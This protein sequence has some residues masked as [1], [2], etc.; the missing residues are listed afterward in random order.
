MNNR[1]HLGLI[2]SFKNLDKVVTSYKFTLNEFSKSFKNLYI[3][4]S[5]YLKFFPDNFQNY[6][7]LDFGSDLS[8]KIKFINLEN[9][10]AFKQFIHNKKIILI[11]TLGNSFPEMKI[12]YFLNQENVELIMISN[13]G[14]IQGSAKPVLSKFISYYFF[15]KIPYLIS[16]MLYGIGVFKKIK[17]RF[18]T[19]KDIYDNFKKKTFSYV[20]KILL[21]N[22]RSFDESKLNDKKIENNSIVFLNPDINHPEWIIKRGFVGQNDEIKIYKI[23]EIFLDSLYLFYKKKIIVCIHPYNNLRKITNLFKKYEVVQFKTVENVRNAHL[24][25]FADSSSITD[26]ITLK[27]RIVCIKKIEMQPKAL[28]FIPSYHNQGLFEVILKENFKLNVDGLEKNILNSIKNYD[29]LNKRFGIPD[30]ENIGVHKVI[31]YIN[32]NY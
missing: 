1:I 13:V 19:N 4:N 25:V 16:L 31:N 21:I 3:V 18:L 32:N 24:V 17:V 26:A 20:E 29:K 7:N 15:K 27:K 5:D 8:K 14:N 23:F 2:T 11:D 28:N 10:K 6:E 9:Y 12:R 30:G 22:S